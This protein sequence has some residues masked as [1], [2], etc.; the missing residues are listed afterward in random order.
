MSFRE[1]QWLAPGQAP[2][3]RPYISHGFQSTVSCGMEGGALA[4]LAGEGGTD[5]LSVPIG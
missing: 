1:R 2:G 5:L 3:L 4:T